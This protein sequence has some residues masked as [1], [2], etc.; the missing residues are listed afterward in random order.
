M[1]LA[2]VGGGI[3]GLSLAYFLI[4]QNF[5]G[6]IHLFEK[7]ASFGGKIETTYLNT[8]LV[9]HGADSIL[10]Q[11]VNVEKLLKDLIGTEGFIG[12][13]TEGFHVLS[14]GKKNFIPSGVALSL[15]HI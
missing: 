13:N 11:G 4:E 1:R 8:S 9:E 5:D 15:I 6:E 2:I 10:M 3:S 12:L 14:N 7:E